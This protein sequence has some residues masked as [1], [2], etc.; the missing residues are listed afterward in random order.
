MRGA[1]SRMSQG[2]MTASV[3]LR[4]MHKLRPASVRSL[5]SLSPAC[6]RKPYQRPSALSQ[7]EVSYTYV[8][9]M[10]CCTPPSVEMQS[11]VRVCNST[12]GLGAVQMSGR[13]RLWDT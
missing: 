1:I 9:S 11:T 2:A 10:P 3:L 13:M 12:S 7:A 8:D 4:M 6:P 5:R